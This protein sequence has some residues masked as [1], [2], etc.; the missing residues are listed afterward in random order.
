MPQGADRFSSLSLAEPGIQDYFR[1][2]M[3]ATIF[4]KKDDKL[5]DFISKR[6]ADIF[7]PKT[8]G[9]RA[10]SEVNLAERE[11]EAKREMC[12]RDRPYPA[13]Q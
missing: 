4:S 13:P 2:A 12:I 11:V 7:T 10:S 6:Y 8:G 9:F 3:G 1:Q 5:L